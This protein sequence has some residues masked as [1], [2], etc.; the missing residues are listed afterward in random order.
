MLFYRTRTRKY[1]KGYG[2]LSFGRNLTNKYGKQLLNT[3]KSAFKKVIH[4]T[5]ETTGQLI[6]N[7]IADKTAKPK[8]VSDENSRNVEEKFIPPEK[9]EE[10]YNELRQVF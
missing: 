3:A 9:T 2:F 4:K 5:A 6:E 7:I 1:V 10:I 8:P